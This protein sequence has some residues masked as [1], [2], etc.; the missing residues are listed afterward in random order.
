MTHHAEAASVGPPPRTPYGIPPA[1]PARPARTPVWRR[2]ASLHTDVRAALAAVD[3]LGA[4]TRAAEDEH[5]REPDPDRLRQRLEEAVGG[6]RGVLGDVIGQVGQLEQYALSQRSWDLAVRLRAVSS[7]RSVD[8]MA[9][10]RAAGEPTQTEVEAAARVERALAGLNPDADDLEHGFEDL[11]TG[12]RRLQRALRDVLAHRADRPLSL[13]HLRQVLDG[14]Y[15]SLATVAVG[16]LAALGVAT[17]DG[18]ATGDAAIAAATAVAASGERIVELVRRRMRVLRP[19]QRMQAAHDDLAYLVGDFARAA[20][21]GR[22][23]RDR[24]EDL[25]G[26]ALQESSHAA[27]WAQ[28]LAWTAKHDYA[29]TARQVPVVL[30]E[31]MAAARAE[32]PDALTAATARVREI[33]D[34]L[35]R[36]HLPDPPAHGSSRPAFQG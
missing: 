22:P 32:D 15:R 35:T 13:R 30:G 7:A 20:A 18:A 1:P 14:T 33:H 5:R 16:L 29:V 11:T 31:A 36:Y 2:G 9:M 26:A 24:L 10:L 19:E 28:R 6:A 34:S 4:D 3:R 12:L 27:R 23:D 25:Y 21:A 8:V 17:Q